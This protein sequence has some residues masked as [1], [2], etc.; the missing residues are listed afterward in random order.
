MASLLLW[1]FNYHISFIDLHLVSLLPLF[2]CCSRSQHLLPFLLIPILAWLAWWMAVIMMWLV[3]CLHPA[4]I[5]WPPVINGARFISMLSPCPTNHHLVGKEQCGL[6]E[7]VQVVEEQD[8]ALV[9]EQSVHLGLSGDHRR[10]W[11]CG[12]YF[13]TPV[14]PLWFSCML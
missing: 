5:P 13:D 6:W 8:C 12:G 3:Q 7:R 9:T 2:C 14:Q 11:T 10:S 4:A 1:M